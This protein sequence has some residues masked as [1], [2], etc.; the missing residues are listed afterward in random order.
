MNMD[1]TQELLQRIRDNILF[2]GVD[3][4]W[5]FPHITEGVFILHIR[6]GE[7][8]FDEN[9]RGGVLFLIVE[10]SVEISKRT[11]TRQELL[12]ALLNPKDFFGEL[13]MLDGKPRSAR[14]TALEDSTLITI[15]K[16]TFELMLNHSHAVALNLLR[17]LSNRL[18]TLDTTFILESERRDEMMNT[19]YEQVQQLV[20]AAKILN[21][22][23][24]LEELLTLNLEIALRI[25]R[26]ERGTLYLIDEST[27]ELWSKVLK[28]SEV[29]EI[30]LPFGSGIAGYVAQSGKIYR[31]DDVYNDPQF[32]A[33]IDRKTGYRTKSMLCI[34]VKEKSGKIIGVFQLLNKRNGVFSDDDVQL[35][36]ALSVHVAI[37]V[38]NAQVAQ[39]MVQNER[40][41]AVGKMAAAIV[42]DIKNPLATLRL[43]AEIIKRRIGNQELALQAEQI[44]FQVDRFVKMAQEILDFTRGVTQ[45]SIQNVLFDEFMHKMLQFIRRDFESRNVTVA[46]QLQFTGRLHIDEDKILRAFYNICGNAA[47]AM[48][49]GGT[50][51]IATRETGEFAIIEFTDTGIGMSAEI[52]SRVFEPFMTHGKTVGTGLGMAIVKKI[53]EDHKG[54]IEIDSIVGK[55]TTIRVFLPV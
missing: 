37:A 41:A 23:L 15:S 25:I 55:G 1:T 9:T 44:I 39:S 8:I 16:T 32:D 18:R 48:P 5:F 26:A 4:E 27:M 12:L 10:G 34:P 42:H 45:L 47:D 2:D 13:E 33:L 35:A 40:L 31:N 49:T 11:K 28:A 29:I 3:T 52:K 14:A 36:E 7:I 51:T 38:T 53:I 30:R 21:S 50:L 22:S 54:K 6:R 46:E 17:T 19:R 24:D 43:N 20:E